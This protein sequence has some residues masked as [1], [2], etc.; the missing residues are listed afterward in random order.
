GVDQGGWGRERGGNCDLGAYAVIRADLAITKTGPATATLNQPF[1]YTITVTNN[2]PSTTQEA[3]I[4]D[5][6]PTGL[7]FVS[8]TPSQGSCSFTGTL[9]CPFGPLANG[10]SATALVT[11]TPTTGGTFTNTATVS[12]VG[13]SIDTVAGNNSSSASTT[14]AAADLS[15]TKTA[16]ATVA[17]GQQFTYTLAVHNGGPN[18]ATGVAVTDTLPAGVTFVSASTGC[19]NA[20]GTVTCTVGNLAN[21]AN[22]TITIV[23]TAPSTAGTITNTAPVAGQP[24]DPNTANNTA[25]AT[26]QVQ[27]ATADLSIAKTAPATVSTG[28]QFTYT[29]SV[30]NGGPSDATSVTVTD[31]LPT[32]VAF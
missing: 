21:G 24:T 2:G 9:L 23:V 4:S 5:T 11:V 12:P 10:A 14:V 28:Q 1:T 6:F 26:T 15:I 20:S 29:L 13:R 30:H 32:G 27:A 31:N 22:A 3:R 18:D 19:T 17:A 8:A 7:T 16:P 25:S